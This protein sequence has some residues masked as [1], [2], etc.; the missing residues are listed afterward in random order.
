MRYLEDFE[1]GQT[2]ALGE[3]SLTAEDVVGFAER[4]DPQTFHLTDDADG[5]FGGLIA[6]GWQTGSCCQRLLVANL[7]ADAAC[8][9]S[10]GVEQIRFL[11]PV[12][13]DVTYVA[14]FSV[15]EV[16]ASKSR[17]DRGKILSQ[18]VLRDP[19]GTS[20]YTLDAVVMFLRRQATPG[21]VA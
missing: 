1:V 8:L 6:S 13:P 19:E 20:V 2:F 16:T 18:L 7:L 3:F 21:N 4:Y 12:L 9:G 5:P 17:P 15:L 14:T 11:K 10:P